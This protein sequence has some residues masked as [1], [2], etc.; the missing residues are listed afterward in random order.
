MRTLLAVG[1]CGVL[2]LGSAAVTL[3]GCISDGAPDGTASHERVA[4]TSA[5]LDSDGG[6][7][8]FPGQVVQAVCTRL[9][10]CCEGSD[11]S[12][13]NMSQCISDFEAA[14]G[15]NGDGLYLATSALETDGGA[16]VT[17]N[18]TSA[19]TCLNDIAAMGCGSDQDT[20]WQQTTSDCFGALTGLIPSGGTYCHGS[21]ECASGSYCDVA[22]GT[23]EPILALGSACTSNDQCE[24]RGTVNITAY[25]DVGYPN[26][27]SGSQTCVSATAVGGA[28]GLTYYYEQECQTF[29]CNPDTALC[30]TAQL[31]SDV[32]TAGGLCATLTLGDAGSADGSCS[33]TGINNQGQ[34]VTVNTCGGTVCGQDDAT[35]V[36]TGSGFVYQGDACGGSDAGGGDAGSGGSDASCSCTGINNQ[37]QPVTS[38]TCGSTVC[39][40]DDLTWLCTSSG[41]IFQGDACT[42]GG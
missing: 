38:N 20:A 28:C 13:F 8:S 7:A 42:D 22:T 31:F 6:A 33:C 37:G 9:A 1:V 25:C 14:G 36:C 3:E 40:Q 23:C 32:G 35:W 30:D 21:I 19:T 39:G 18:Q 15:F 26:P 27:S 10:T 4:V 11:T 17:F 16:Q 2:T 41:Y 34:Q 29:V 12:A 24:Y 5:A